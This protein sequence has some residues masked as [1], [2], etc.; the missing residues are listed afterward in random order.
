[1]RK[2]VALAVALAPWTVALA[3]EPYVVQCRVGN[4]VF[5]TWYEP[6]SAVG[7]P[8]EKVLPMHMVL[9]Q[10]G[11]YQVEFRADRPFSLYAYRYDPAQRNWQFL[12]SSAASRAEVDQSGRTIQY[13]DMRIAKTDPAM[14]DYLFQAQPAAEAQDTRHRY[15][16]VQRTQRCG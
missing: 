8:G 5:E 6:Q 1:M 4:E 3:Q 12:D 2:L 14:Q 13:W 11:D 9:T 16:F 7:N 15:Q 10:S